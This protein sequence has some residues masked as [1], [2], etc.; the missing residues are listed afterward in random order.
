MSSTPQ[1]VIGTSPG[2]RS[3]EGA[4]PLRFVCREGDVDDLHDQLAVE[5]RLDEL[6]S[7][8]MSEDLRNVAAGS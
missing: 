2:D 6:H 7:S 3:D 8:R 1:E 5:D 4:T